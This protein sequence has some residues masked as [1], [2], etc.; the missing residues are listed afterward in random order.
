MEAEFS[1]VKFYFHFRGDWGWR[2]SIDLSH[3]L[4]FSDNYNIAYEDSLVHCTAALGLL[5][6][7]NLSPVWLWNSIC[8]SHIGD[9]A[10]LCLINHSPSPSLYVRW[11]AQYV[12]REQP[13]H[14]SVVLHGL[15]LIWNLN[16][17]LDQITIIVQR[18]HATVQGS[19]ACAHQN[20]WRKL[21]LS[22]DFGTS[23]RKTWPVCKGST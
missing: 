12:S 22:V 19:W 11:K 3:F 13:L 14:L 5:P 9:S 21:L 17:L 23:Q 18:T 10:I 6:F 4:D 16:K 7:W 15:T 1:Y 8:L 20:Q 2:H